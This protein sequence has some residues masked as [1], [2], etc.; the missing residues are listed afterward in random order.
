VNPL[1]CL[2]CHNKENSPKYDQQVYFPKVTHPGAT[3]AG[4][5]AAVTLGSPH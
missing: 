5:T 3:A 4:K 2:P 1:G